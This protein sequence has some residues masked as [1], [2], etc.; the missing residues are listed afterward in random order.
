MREESLSPELADVLARGLEATA[1]ATLEHF[2]ENIFWD[3]DG[4]ASSVIRDA[5]KHTD[6]AA[7][8]AA[9]FD[10]IASLYA[11]FGRATAIRFRYVHD[12]VYGF[13]WAKWVRRDPA[14]RAGVGPFDRVFLRALLARGEELLD[15]IERDDPEYPRLRDEGSRSPF[16]FSREPED[17]ARLHRSLVG[18]ALIPVRAWCIDP[19]PVW[20]RPFAELR[21]ARAAAMT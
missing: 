20:D 5:W 16:P 15:L 3:L 19:E 18:E 7:S 13:D 9:A 10:D 17:E 6:P 2:P 4:L 8:L 12:F 21:A 14:A 11:V 1:L